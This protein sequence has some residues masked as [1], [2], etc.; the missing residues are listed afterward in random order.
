M[1]TL[2]VVK[3]NIQRMAREGEVQH[4]RN[5]NHKSRRATFF[6]NLVQSIIDSSDSFKVNI[7]ANIPPGDISFFLSLFVWTLRN[8]QQE[9]F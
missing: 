3:L 9:L 8:S 1:T 4:V 7:I 5:N 2:P 6:C